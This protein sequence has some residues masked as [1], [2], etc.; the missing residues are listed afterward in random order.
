MSDA[1]IVYNVYNFS[2]ASNLTR[3]TT[4]ISPVSVQQAH[5]ISV[6]LASAITFRSLNKKINVTAQT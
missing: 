1:T 2:A 6:T 3:P 4:E 5:P